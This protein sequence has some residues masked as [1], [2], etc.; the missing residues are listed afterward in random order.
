[1]ATQDHCSVCEKGKGAYFCIG[2]KKHFCKKDFQ[3]HREILTNEL[4]RFVEDRNALQE[5]ITKATQQK[6]I[7]SPLFS[8]IDQWQK[9]TIEKVKQTADQARQNV[10]QILHSKRAEITSNFEKFSKELIQLK[11]TEDFAEQ[12]LKRL[13]QTIDQLTQGVKKLAQPS[14]IELHVDESQEIEWNRL[15]Y[16]VDNTNYV[17]NQQQRTGK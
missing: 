9:I 10:R 17:A 15:I 11:E 7:S 3:N 4:D 8:Q 12:D 13:K 16:V 5:T 6:D 1:M 14:E 2:C